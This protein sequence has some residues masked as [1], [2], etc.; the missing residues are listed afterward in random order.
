MTKIVAMYLPQYHRIPEN[1]MWWGEGYTDWKAVKDAK[2][3][4]KMHKQPRVPYNKIYYDLADV[5]AIKHQAELANEYGIYG[6]GI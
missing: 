1:D 4:Y 5:D 2:P 6:F 3:L